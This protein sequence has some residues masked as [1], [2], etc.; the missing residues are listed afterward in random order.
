MQATGRLSGPWRE[1]GVVSPE[2]RYGFPAVA[3]GV[4]W[5]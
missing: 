5:G 4:S 2:A 1:F 3:L